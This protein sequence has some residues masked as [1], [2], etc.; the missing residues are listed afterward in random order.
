MAMHL[1]AEERG[2]PVDAEQERVLMAEALESSYAMLVASPTMAIDPC[3]PISYCPTRE[4]TSSLGSLRTWPST[5]RTLPKER[6]TVPSGRLGSR[7]P[8]A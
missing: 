4:S 2:V 7:Y 8:R 6:S 3:R 1:D 5:V